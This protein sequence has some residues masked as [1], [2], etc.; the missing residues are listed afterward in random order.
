MGTPNL[1]STHLFSTNHRTRIATSHRVDPIDESPP[2]LPA[3]RAIFNEE[4]GPVRGFLIVH[5]NRRPCVDIPLHVFVHKNVYSVVAEEKVLGFLR[6][7]QSQS[8]TGT[9]STHAR[10]NDS[11]R[12]LLVLGLGHNGQKLFLGA[13]CNGDVHRI[14]L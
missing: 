14:P 13:V 8:Q 10:K 3:A 5:G 7:I 11:K 2:P 4:P 9:S 1:G 6:L 12:R